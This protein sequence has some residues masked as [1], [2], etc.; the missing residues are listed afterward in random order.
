MANVLDTSYTF[1]VGGVTYSFTT[2]LVGTLTH[3]PTAVWYLDFA[4]K[5]DIT[6]NLLVANRFPPPPIS[7]FV[8]GQ[9]AEPYALEDGQSL[10]VAAPSY[11]SV[12]N[13]VD[14]P[15]SILNGQTLE[16]RIDGGYTQTI[17]LSGLTDGTA[18]APE[19]ATSIHDQLRLARA[20]VTS[21]GSRVT[22]A[23]K[24]LGTEGSVEVVGGTAALSMLW[25]AGAQA[26]AAGTETVVF[27]AVAGTVTTTATALY[28]LSDFMTLT[29][30]VDGGAP[31]TVTFLTAD[32]EDIAQ[33]TAQEVADVITAQLTGASGATAEAGAKVS[34]TSSTN[35]SSSSIE[36]TGGTAN[37]VLSFPGGAQAGSGD[38][39]TL[40]Q[41]TAV[42]VRDYLNAALTGAEAVIASGG[43]RVRLVAPT[44]DRI[45]CSGEAAYVLALAAQAQATS[46]ALEPYLNLTDGQT[47]AVKI[48]GGAEQTIALESTPVTDV[49]GAPAE[50]IAELLDTALVGASAFA[51]A[52]GT[53]IVIRSD[54]Q[55]T[56]SSVQVTGGTA[57]TVL[58]FSTTVSEGA[59]RGTAVYAEG[60]HDEDI[61]L[62][63]FDAGVSGWAQARV[64]V[65][66]GFV[67]TLVYDSLGSTASGWSVTQSQYSAPGSGVND[68]WRIVLSH[69]ASFVSD[70][71]V[72]VRV[73]AE[74]NLAETIDE[75][76]YFYAEDTKQPFVSKISMTSPRK[77]RVQ[78]N[79]P[80][81][82]GTDYTSAIYF[83]DVS[84]RVTYHKTI[85]I[86][87]TDYE[88]VIIAPT[89]SFASDSVG[90]F[91][92][93]WGA[94][95]AVNN[96]SFEITQ[97][98]ASDTVK[99]DASLA[100]EAAADLQTQAAPTLVLT[101][102]RIARTDP[103]DEIRPTAAPIVI[104]AAEASIT[105]VPSGAVQS[106]F[107]DIELIDDLTPNTSYNLEVV[108]V[109]DLA[110]NPVGS[111]YPFTSWQLKQVPDREWDL[112]NMIPAFN[113]EK[114]VTQ[115]L[116]RFIKT[117]NETAQVLL[118]DVDRFG[119]LLDPMAMKDDV[120]DVMLESLGNPLA[121][122]G[123]LSLDKKRDLIPL[124]V[125]MYKLKG[126]AKGIEDA[127]TFFVGK[128]VT[129]VPWEL[130]AD[131]WTIGSSLLGFNTYV[132]PSKSYVRYSFRLQH[133]EDLT[134]TDKSRIE[135]IVEFI[136]PA[137]TH[138]VGYLQV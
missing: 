45:V 100:D 19:V 74:N 11:G 31:Q 119:D 61:E 24:E 20:T 26:G 41:A 42:E 66:T 91:L 68:V 27:T 58:S 122:V 138:F 103:D 88:N 7:A 78:Y 112:W 82:Q 10:T 43:T 29:V 50:F 85:T 124:L 35:G 127:V 130:P 73:L 64:W 105:S 76:W 3:A 99:V 126:V 48:D 79:E 135:E 106:R 12:E 81:N 38:F 52:E 137:H 111:L 69:T 6:E 86:G 4:K 120:V 93:S 34:I 63:L 75:T 53:R 44:G 57:N 121:F 51:D 102:Y 32:F 108:K 17:I 60:L 110:G 87:S 15:W 67:T 94:Q 47:L 115:D 54:T 98:I 8:E 21:G 9:T 39:A 28:A 65:T 25:P 96:G 36:V 22:L 46:G 136:R 59:G 83:D 13:G 33:A 49:A 16:I 40:Q 113:K 23:T 134:D 118:H 97:V 123:G 125:P 117:L 1:E 101:P 18:T 132:G 104:S 55:T 62:E 70:E 95:N 131:T 30:A 89:A 116:E 90:L 37:A 109:S 2:E 129:V 56:A 71:R 5:Q 84:G 128:D 77:L 80:M 72:T 114:D 14:A 92:G 133:A 107:V